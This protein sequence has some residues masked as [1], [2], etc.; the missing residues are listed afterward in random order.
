MKKELMEQAKKNSIFLTE[1]QAEQF[2]MYY[3]ILIE[4]N[5]VMNL[6]AITEWKDV[7][8]K[9]F[10]DSLAPVSYFEFP[11]NGKLIDVGTGAGFPGIPLKIAFPEWKITLMDSL[12]KRVLFLEEIIDRLGLKKIEVIHS[13]AE[14]LGR[15]STYREKYDYCVSRAVANLTVLSEYCTPFLK[16]GGVFV[17]YKSGK[18][19]EEW[20]EAQ[21]AIY[22]LGCET[23]KKESTFLPDSDIERTFLFIQRKESISKK[24]PRKAGTPAKE[25]LGL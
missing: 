24:Y 8:T 22:M 20:R 9:H 4:K 12:K 10:I 6:T 19:E 2:L 1:E 11:D 18:V 5:K 15:N 25:P 13:R 7:L 23:V 14:E 3:E 17:A 16:K 21:K